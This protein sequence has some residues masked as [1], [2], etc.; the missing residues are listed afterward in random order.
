MDKPQATTG[1]IQ[2]A[3]GFC[4][5]PTQKKEEHDY[6]HKPGCTYYTKTQ[7]HESIPTPGE[8]IYKAYTRRAQTAC[9]HKEAATPPIETDRPEVA[10]DSASPDF[11]KIRRTLSFHFSNIVFLSF[12]TVI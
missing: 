3:A 8:A 9:R 5:R 2:P 6:V 4:S 12:F 1:T 10:R 11:R 7:Y